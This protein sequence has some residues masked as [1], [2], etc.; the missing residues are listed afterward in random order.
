MGVIFTM[1]TEAN[2]SSQNLSPNKVDK[3][4]YS[5][6]PELKEEMLIAKNWIKSSDM[7][8]VIMN[9]SGN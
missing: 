8:K 3:L 6:I 7:N 5:N 1:I 4:F 9:A 2:V